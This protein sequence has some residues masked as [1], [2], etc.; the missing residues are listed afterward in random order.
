MIR[1][2]SLVCHFP[3]TARPDDLLSTTG[4][5]YAKGRIP[6]S[7]LERLC[8][9]LRLTQTNTSTLTPTRPAAHTEIPVREPYQRTS[10]ADPRRSQWGRQGRRVRLEKELGG[11]RSLE[12][13]R[14][15]FRKGQRGNAVF[16][17]SVLLR[18]LGY[19]EQ[20]RL[21]SRLWRWGPAASRLLR[22]RNAWQ[23]PLSPI[24]TSAANSLGHVVRSC[25][26]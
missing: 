15:G 17:Q 3:S 11:L 8:A 6:A 25:I 5:K 21:K 24:S 9:F 4:S 22:K 10:D 23:W 12:R 14:G 26:C 13:L 20:E 7:T 18:A 1:L 19:D 16:T 2:A